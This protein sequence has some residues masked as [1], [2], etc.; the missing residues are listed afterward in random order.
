MKGRK[1]PV[2]EALNK[3]NRPKKIRMKTRY[4]RKGRKNG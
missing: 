3:L 1:N 4:T 2:A